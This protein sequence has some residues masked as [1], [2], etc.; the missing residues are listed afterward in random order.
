MKGFRAQIVVST[1]LLV[2]AAMFAVVLGTEVVLELSEGHPKAHSSLDI[3]VASGFVGVFG[4]VS[5]ALVAW[6]VSHRALQPVRQM[7]ERAEEWLSLIHI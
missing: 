3:L 6:N 4:V 1:V 5:A 2:A 7:A